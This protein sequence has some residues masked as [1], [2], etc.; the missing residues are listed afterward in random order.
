MSLLE[1]RTNSITWHSDVTYENQPPGTS[2][3]YNLD[4][5]TAGG[6]TL[7][8]NQAAAYNRLSPE[9]Q[10][11]LHGLKVLHSGKRSPYKCASCDCR[12][13]PNC[14]AAGYEQAQNSLT[15]GGVVRREPVAS[16]H[17]LVRTHPA[18]GE[19][20]LYV[21]QQCETIPFHSRNNISKAK[22]IWQL[23]AASSDTNRRRATSFS[24]SST[25]ISHLVKISKCE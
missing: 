2:F 17:P 15:R 19:K 9:F 7:F 24:N 20:G 23:P 5:P 22:T 21:N 13:C 18:T 4:T 6:D 11:R 10:K 14:S 1:S 3:L 16:I 8:A 12:H 25:T